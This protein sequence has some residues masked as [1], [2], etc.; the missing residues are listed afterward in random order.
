MELYA[1]RFCRH[2]IAIGGYKLKDN[3]VE[4]LILVQNWRQLGD[5]FSNTD[6]CEGVSLETKV[7][8]QI[9]NSMFVLNFQYPFLFPIL[10]NILSVYLMYQC[11]IEITPFLDFRFFSKSYLGDGSNL[12]CFR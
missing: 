12:F 5:L 2:I 3:I 8:S 1:N 4:I 10:L 7:P 6:I 9:E 11:K